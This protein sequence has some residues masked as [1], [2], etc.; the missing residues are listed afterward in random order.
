MPPDLQARVTVTGVR[1]TLITRGTGFDETTPPT[2]AGTASLQ[3]STTSWAEGS[4]FGDTMAMFTVGQ[5]CGASGA[6]WDEPNCAGGTAW[7]G[8]AVA[9]AVSGTASVP[10]AL[11]AMVAWDSGSG[12]GGMLTD[13]QSWIDDPTTNHGWRIVSSTEGGATGAAQKFYS[14]EEVGDKG[15]TLVIDYT[16]KAGLETPTCAPT[17]ASDDAVSDGGDA[18]AGGGGTGG[19]TAGAGWNWRRRR[20]GGHDRRRDRW[21]RR[22]VRRRGRT[23][24]RWGSG[25]HR[26]H[27][28][29]D[30]WWRRDDRGHG[31]RDRW[32]RRDD[33]VAPGERE[34]PAAAEQ[35]GPAASPAPPVRRAGEAAAR[36]WAAAPW[37]G[38]AAFR[39]PRAQADA[40]A[41]TRWARPERPE[42]AAAPAARARSPRRVETLAVPRV[43]SC[44][45]GFDAARAGVA[46][47]W[48]SSLTDG[49][50]AR[51]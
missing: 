40:A 35:A 38:A 2:A 16:C 39:A 31:W 42:A 12:G 44:S 13:V 29:R 11:E 6:T 25:H 3:G 50:F 17:D 24:R 15:P 32:W 20:R 1:L 22:G 30:R 19:G 10:A 14:S 23:R 49:R 34:P 28:W 26:G 36:D 46:R 43:C 45:Q 27:G 21:R 47:G 7:A 41:A 51:S 18:A 8:G 9:S 37:P 4:G 5:P 48:C 33:L